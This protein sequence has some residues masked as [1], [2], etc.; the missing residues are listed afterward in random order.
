MAVATEILGSAVLISGL[1]IR[2]GALV[3]AGYVFILNFFYFDFWNLDGVDA[4]MARKAFLKDLAV[5]AGLLLMIFT[6]IKSA[7]ARWLPEC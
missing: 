2:V 5:I 3:L 4:V 1:Y 7:K 6:S